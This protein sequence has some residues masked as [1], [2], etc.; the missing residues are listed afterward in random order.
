MAESLKEKL[1]E[2]WLS[3]TR[4]SEE[5]AMSGIGR[6]KII[7]FLISVTLAFSIWLVVNLNRDYNIKLKIPIVMGN[8]STDQVLAEELPDAVTASVN[9]DGWSLINIYQAPPEVFIDVTQEEVNLFEQIRQQ[10]SA[11]SNVTVQTVDPLSLQLKL[12][13]RE[14]KKVP[15]VSN[16]DVEFAPQFGFLTEPVLDPDSIIVQ[17]AGSRISNINRW[18]TKALQLTNIKENIATEVALKEPTSLITLSQNNVQYRGEI[19]EFTEA[20]VSVP[21]ETRDF[22]TGMEVTFSPST[23]NIVYQ[24]PLKEFAQ[25]QNARAFTAYVTYEQIQQDTSGF[26][27]VQVEKLLKE[28]HLNFRKVSP[29][30]VAYFT[31]IGS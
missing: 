22:P 25:Y 8:I 15:V 4:K 28:A 26:V 17:G 11:I 18:P 10:I 12:E 19:A 27:S 13:E 6:E 14:S 3:L 24:I 20:E 21:V 7:V 9:G 16:V 2:M 31:V 29:S 1:N 30:K 23:V 5:E